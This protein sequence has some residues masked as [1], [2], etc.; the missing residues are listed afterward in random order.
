MPLLGG[1]ANMVGGFVHDAG[2]FMQGAVAN[3]RGGQ[4]AEERTY[5]EER[6]DECPNLIRD[7]DRASGDSYRLV[8]Y[9]DSGSFGDVFEVEQAR[10]L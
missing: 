2:E 5:A 9:M 4:P 7:L 1:A 6:N 3:A 8:K 10:E